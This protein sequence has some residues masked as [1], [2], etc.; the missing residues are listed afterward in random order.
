MKIANKFI[1]SFHQQFTKELTKLQNYKIDP[2]S[3]MPK[4]LTEEYGIEVICSIRKGHFMII[5]N[6]YNVGRISH[7]FVTEDVLDA[8]DITRRWSTKN[9]QVAFRI[10]N[11]REIKIKNVSFDGIKPFALI[12]NNIEMYIDNMDFSLPIGVKK[13]IKYAMIFSFPV[14]VNYILNIDEYTSNFI[15]AYWSYYDKYKE[16]LDST[17]NKYEEYISE[18]EKIKQKMN[19]YFYDEQVL[20]KD[21]ENFIN[22]NSIIISQILGLDK[23]ILQAEL[24]DVIGKFGQTLKPDLMGF[25][26]IR[27]NWTIVDYKL[28]RGANLVQSPGGVRVKFYDSVAKLEAQLRIYRKYFNEEDHRRYFNK[29]YKTK[30]HEFPE[31]IGI[32]GYVDNESRKDFNELLDEKQ[33][34]FNLIPYNDLQTRFEKFISTIKSIN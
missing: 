2:K 6:D 31:T 29:K 9:D 24:K 28:G 12:G 33:R 1:Q 23:S 14:L 27:D 17:S 26:S 5:F 20:E 21:I 34:W 13:N 32:I 18:L 15:F 19:Y 30:I 4:I 11:G 7:K 16:K 25:D 3:F 10:E 8:F 22:E